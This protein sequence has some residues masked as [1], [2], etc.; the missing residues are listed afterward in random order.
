MV[1]TVMTSTILDLE[2]HLIPAQGAG[3]VLY[4]YVGDIVVTHD[5]RRTLEVFE[6]NVDEAVSNIC[7]FVVDGIIG[8]RSR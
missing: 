8:D 3:D 1:K 2:E 6:G 5:I 4:V 7:T